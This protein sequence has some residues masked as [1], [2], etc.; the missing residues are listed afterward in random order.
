MTGHFIIPSLTT[1]V[2]AFIAAIMV[3]TTDVADE[4][5]P[6]YYDYLFIGMIISSISLPAWAIAMHPQWWSGLLVVG[7]IFIAGQL[8][9]H[10]KLLGSFGS[11]VVCVFTAISCFSS[12]WTIIAMNRFS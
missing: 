6:D 11:T 1:L 2:S 8:M 3:H 12:I 9:L 5:R 10:F 4:R 7:G